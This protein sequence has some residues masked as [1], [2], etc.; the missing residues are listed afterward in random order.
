MWSLVSL[1]VDP[2]RFRLVKWFP[3]DRAAQVALSPSKVIRLSG[4]AAAIGIDL[5]R[6]RRDNGRG[7]GG[8][9]K[10]ERKKNNRNSVFLVLVSNCVLVLDVRPFDALRLV[11]AMKGIRSVETV[12]HHYSKVRTAI[13]KV[14]VS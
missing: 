10:P 6:K 11:T 7:I 8:E 4:T 3:P 5:D 13:K 1:G 12:P 14:R 9:T 2:P